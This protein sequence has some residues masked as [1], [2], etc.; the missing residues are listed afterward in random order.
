MRKLL[1]AL[2]WVGWG[3]LFVLVLGIT[4]LAVYTHT[5]RFREFA[6][7]KLVEAIND[8]IRG[9]VSVARLEGSIWGDLT[10]IDLRVSDVQS[11]ILRIPRGRINY[12]L[13]PL[14]WGQVQIFQLEASEPIV[15]LQK[16][17]DGAWNIVEAFAPAE[18]KPTEPSKLIVSLNSVLLQQASVDLSLPEQPSY[19]L[20]DLNMRGTV[21]IRPA[22]LTVDLE[23]VSS[24]V[25]V[26]GLPEARVG[27]AFAYQNTGAVDVFSVQDFSI[28][29][30]ESRVRLT[31]K[32]NDLQKFYTEARI[33]LDKLAPTD[34][35][36]FIP[37]WPIKAPLA[38]TLDLRGPASA[39]NGAL[40]IAVAGGSLSGNFTADVT[41]EKPAYQSN[42]KIA[43][44]NL[45]T[46][47]AGNDLQGVVSGRVETTG[48]GFAPGDIVGQAE[49]EVRSAAWAGWQLGQLSL[50]TK[51]AQNV[52]KV[53]GRLKSELGQAD[54]QGQ[55]AFKDQPR[56]E[57]AFSA[58]EVDVQKISSGGK[59]L[60]GSVNLDGLVKGSGLTTAAMN[61][62]AKINVRRSTVAEVNL[63][64]GRLIASV[65]NQRIRV[66]EAFLKATDATLTAKGEIGIDLK[67]QGNLDYRL[68]VENL[69][70]WLGLVD[71]KGSGSIDVAGTAT[72]NLADLKTQGKLTLSSARFEGTAVQ[73]GSIVYNLNYADAQPSPHGTLQVSLGDIR[74]AYH[75]QALEGVV[76]I[77]PR[78]PYVFEVDTQAR[79][80]DGRT[81]ALAAHLEYR[82]S[83]LVARVTRLTL[84]LPDGT[85][86]LAQPATLTQ[87]EDDFLIER[88][89]LRNNDRQL[90]LDGR[91]SLSGSQRLR[92]TVDRLPVESIRAFYP[93]APDISGILSGQAQVEG[94]AAA[95]EIAATMK[96]E[97]SKIAGHSYEGLLATATYRNQKMDL[98]ATLQQDPTH[99]LSAVVALPA[100]VSWS[101]GWRA[102][103]PGKIT[104]R[105]QSD[106]L[107]IAFLNAFTG[108]AIQSIDGEVT[109]DVRLDGTV[110]QPVAQGFLR[111]RD[112][113]LNPSALGV[114]ISSVNAEALLEPKGIRVSQ[115]SARAQNGELNGT[116]FIGLNNFSLQN[117]KLSIA[118]KRWPAI[119]TQQ[120]QAEVNGAVNVDGTVATPR[121]TGKLE[122]VR[123]EVRPDLSFLDR[124]GST[125]PKRD[126]T[127]TVVSTSD[128]QASAANKQANEKR[129]DN[130]W[131]R[132]LMLDLQVRIPNNAWVRHRNATAE[133]SGNLRVSKSKEGQPIITGSIEVVRGWVGFQGRRFTLVRGKVEF[134]GSDKIN[135]VIEI[136]AEYRV[137]SYT[138]NAIVSGTVE[139][140]TLTLTSQPQLD[141]ADI[142]SLLLFNKPISAL[143]KGEQASLQQNAIGI[144][145][146]FAAARIGEAVSKALGLEDLGIDLGALDFSGGQVRFGQYLGR[147]T[148][149][150]VGQEISGEG[151]RQI[152]AEY[153]IT[154]DWKLSVTS[155]TDGTSGVDLIWHKR[156]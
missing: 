16:T 95:P 142:L 117:I 83:N 120:Y 69:E 11:E 93:D 147:K 91:F 124:G 126:P 146:G 71:Q 129:A 100:I 97:N 138:V 79:D 153:Q 68:R 108:K 17:R 81:H 73:R 5:E 2:R 140:P 29:S 151:G 9:K 75:L 19:R 59:P 34:A 72:G 30:G 63:E 136:V 143:E 134:V 56:Y 60:K 54:W 90:A 148:F 96:L 50:K 82:P 94:T 52:A 76:R 99:R 44:V 106:G 86:R 21:G 6:R 145:T 110:K 149:V 92:M 135:P 70:P 10:V 53:E 3:L 26:E 104:G 1:S 67:Q 87:R 98:K 23:P 18:P 25:L 155:T 42:A 133:L 121:I 51:L 125:P 36:R 74:G 61:A 123:A 152:A 33:T 38:G 78:E 27:G 57:L 77:L 65:A 85:W 141:Q 122:V 114:Q 156:Y 40:S 127:I 111:L 115:L 88:L 37:E 32:L 131:L 154:T 14:L 113:R 8:S 105:V 107:S 35:A 137:D 144:T 103:V 89:S 66:A 47:L 119:H 130:E 102:E 109:V 46:L 24:R 62:E 43:D 118:A 28:E 48:N 64:Q 139:K 116:G 55:I 12:S 112:G 132:N 80:A 101:N 84:N 31:G 128:V 41:R 15:S 39:L 13:L 22:G 4:V 20:R 58:R 7:Q 49:I 150:S 45:A